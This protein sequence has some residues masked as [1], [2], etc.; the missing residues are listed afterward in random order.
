[1]FGAPAEL[2]SWEPALLLFLQARGCL[3]LEELSP[4]SQI[5][6]EHRARQRLPA[7][8]SCSRGP[9]SDSIG[10]TFFESVKYVLIVDPHLSMTQAGE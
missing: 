2:S 10:M 7:S 5:W 8:D 3:A 9:R 1:M 6:S 4:S